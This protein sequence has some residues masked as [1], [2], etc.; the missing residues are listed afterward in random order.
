MAYNSIIL[1]NLLHAR[2]LTV[3]GLSE[4]LDMKSDELIRELSR[5]PQPKQ[6]LLKAIAAELVVPDFIFYMSDTPSLN[7]G[8]PDFRS[9]TPHA[10]PKTKFTLKSIQLAEAIQNYVAKRGSEPIKTL[11]A[12]TAVSRDDV[13]VF[14]EEARAFFG[15]TLKDQ[16]SSR[17]SKVFY[18]ICRRKIE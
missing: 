11:P 15:I 5:E 4:R 16:L 3:A 7:E 8:I 1:E 13:D 17:D 12:F 6:G 18:N 10:V 9:D 14:A 2:S